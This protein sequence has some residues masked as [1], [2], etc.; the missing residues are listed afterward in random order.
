MSPGV[1]PGWEDEIPPQF[2]YHPHCD[3]EIQHK[4]Y[5]HDGEHLFPGQ[6][7]FEFLAN[8]N[9][10]GTASGFGVSRLWYKIKPIPDYECLSAAAA[11]QIRRGIGFL[12]ISTSSTKRKILEAHG[13]KLDPWTTDS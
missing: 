6:H 3:N 5:H 1:V 12:F 7:V 9:F 10:S 4:E 2:R 11:A 13:A 8:S